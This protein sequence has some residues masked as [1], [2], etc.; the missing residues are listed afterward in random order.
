MSDPYV[1]K[2]EDLEDWLDERAAFLMDAEG[3]DEG[4]ATREVARRLVSR[5]G[6]VQGQ[7]KQEWMEAMRARLARR[8]D[9]E[10]EAP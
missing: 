6:P 2:P 7:T 9:G 4:E 3:M 8:K 10:E 5:V 1:P